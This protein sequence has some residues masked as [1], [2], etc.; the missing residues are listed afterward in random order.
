M[1][2]KAF[3]ISD[4]Y[5]PTADVVYYHGDTRD[6]IKTIPDGSVN[7]VVT[8]PP[9][10]IGKVYEK[11]ISLEDYIRQQDEIISSI[12]P[13]VRD[14]GSICWQVG[15]YVENSHIVPLDLE[16]Y[17]IFKR[18][19]LRLRNRIVWTFGHGLHASN[20]FSGRYEVILWFTK[21]DKYTFNLDPVRI[22]Q[23]YPNKKHHKGPKRGQLSGN[24]KGKNPSDVWKFEAEES[25]YVPEDNDVWEIPNV[26]FNHV[27]KTSH[28]AQF[29]VELVQRLI[30]ALTNPGEVIF[31]PFM[32]V[33]STAVAAVKDHRKALGAEIVRAYVDIGIERIRKAANDDLP[34]REIGT[35]VYTPRPAKGSFMNSEKLPIST[36]ESYYE[37]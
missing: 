9:Y 15:N 3:R 22:P 19:N 7:L 1:P 25:K 28:P 27:E 21:S 14:T 26:K 33:G 12:I 2:A 29:P 23:M 11:K 31:D 16:L 30:R 35:P 20:R 17:P 24:P 4:K 10:N 32:G 18:F 8:S 36:E 13:K 37:V 5:E 6:F 34:I